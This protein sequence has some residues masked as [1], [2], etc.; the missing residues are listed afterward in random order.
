MSS[1]LRL[2]LLPL[3]RM[4]ECNMAINALVKGKDPILRQIVNAL[5]EY[6]KAH[7]KVVIEAYR[8][9]SV[10]VRIRIVNPEFAGRT[11]AQREEEV[12]AILNKLPD[13]TVAEISLLL[14]LTP[15]E[16]KNSF[17]SFEF[18]DPIP[19]KLYSVSQS[20]VKTAAVPGWL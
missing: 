11:R 18:D 10:S 17:A 8:Q 5:S 2:L 13:E 19:S 12:W 16:A 3:G 4:G 7:P 14:L 6:D 20:V 1:W 15:D 9:N